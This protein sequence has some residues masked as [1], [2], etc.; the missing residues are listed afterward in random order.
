MKRSP[1]RIRLMSA[2]EHRS[3][4]QQ[5]LETVW[6][7]VERIRDA[8]DPAERSRAARDAHSALGHAIDHVNGLLQALELPAIE[9]TAG[10]AEGVS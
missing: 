10:S 1:E 8:T 5:R 6:A 4:L 3:D 7:T 9:V 2:R